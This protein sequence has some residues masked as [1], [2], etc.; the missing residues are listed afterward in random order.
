MSKVLVMEKVSTINVTLNNFM[1]YVFA[2]AIVLDFNTVWKS[3]FSV[4]KQLPYVILGLMLIS[5]Y[6]YLLGKNIS[7]KQVISVV[8]G[9]FL[10]FGYFGLHYLLRPYNIGSVVIFLL[11]VWILFMLLTVENGSQ[12]IVSL[13]LK[14]KNIMI[15]VAII[16]LFF[17]IFG[18]VLGII[19]STGN[20]QI[21]WAG[22]EN[23]VS[24][25]S[26]YGLYYEAQRIN[27]FGEAGLPRN[28]A[29]FTEAPM[30]SFAFC[31]AFLIEAYL[32]KSV[33]YMTI[34]VL[35]LAIISTISSTGIV[36]LLIMITVKYIRNISGP[37]LKQFFL[38]LGLFGV[39][40]LLGYISLQLFSEKSDT[41]SAILRADDYL[42]GFSAWISQPLF[43]NGIG[44]TDALLAHMDSWRAIDPSLQG[45]SNG[46][47]LI[48]S[49]GGL[50]FFIFYIYAF[51]HSFTMS[52]KHRLWKHLIFSFIILYLFI[53]TVVPYTILFLLLLLYMGL[54][55]S[56]FKRKRFEESVK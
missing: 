37:F 22:G 21:G 32:S 50:Y 20:I 7:K 14:Y 48:L 34:F 2:F 33:N 38:V 36:F 12:E 5:L 17:W 56:Y 30:S 15:V 25:P 45:F 18:S 39:I 28:T 26:Y 6:V 31:A 54:P 55:Y 8:I 1:G 4:S 11:H 42:V 9:T 52:L 41:M 47:F 3:D 43:G 27:T 29:I 16:S 44:N 51:F 23:G 24:I 40:F 53:L 35:S 10:I 46:P 19:S 13:L 49:Q